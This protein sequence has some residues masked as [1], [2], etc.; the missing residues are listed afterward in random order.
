[1]ALDAQ[2]LTFVVPGRPRAKAR[3]RVT[4]RGTY[5]PAITRDAQTRVAAFALAAGARPVTT[6]V[7]MMVEFLTDRRKVDL[8]NLGKLVMDALIGVAYVDDSQVHDL[9]LLRRPGAGRET[10]V[11]LWAL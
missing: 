2:R 11:D 10:R 7:G 5:T 3:P 1:M 9:H 6:P 8:D 4:G